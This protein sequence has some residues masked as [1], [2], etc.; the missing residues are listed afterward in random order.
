[1]LPDNLLVLM[2]AF[3][4]LECIKNGIDF[5]FESKS[6]QNSGLV[7]QEAK[8]MLEQFTAVYSLLELNEIGLRILQVVEAIHMDVTIS[9]RLPQ[10]R[11]QY[12]VGRLSIFFGN[13][14][15]RYEC[16]MQRT[17]YTKIEVMLAAVPSLSVLALTVGSVSTQA[18]VSC[19]WS[20]ELVVPSVTTMYLG[21]AYDLLRAFVKLRSDLYVESFARDEHARPT[22][23]ILARSAMVV[24]LHSLKIVRAA[25]VAN[26]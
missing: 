2:M 19:P 13:L 1:M 15:D 4:F 25:L 18:V 9:I 10:R 17:F 3:L 5:V 11:L 23:I 26:H 21:W 20:S 6:R 16:K 14:S 24:E 8:R 12:K 7:H 22:K